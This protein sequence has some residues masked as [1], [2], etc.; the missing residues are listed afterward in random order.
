MALIR[1]VTPRKRQGG[2]HRDVKRRMVTPRQQFAKE[3][4]MRR[5]GSR[6]TSAAPIAAPG[7]RWIS[8][9]ATG[10]CIWGGVLA[11]E[12]ATARLRGI[13][14]NET[15]TKSTP[16]GA[17]STARSIRCQCGAALSAG[18]RSTR[19]RTRSSAASVA[20]T[21]GNTSREGR[22]P[23]RNA[24]WRSF[25]KERAAGRTTRRSGGSTAKCAAP[26]S[27]LTAG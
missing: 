25:R 4:P 22:Q 9:R 23:E 5:S 6:K 18:S 3:T 10:G 7:C 19:G 11:V 20:G 26:G 1:R 13:G 16:L 14:G 27:A 12:G 21:A 24:R 8:F 2:Y 15:A 17:R